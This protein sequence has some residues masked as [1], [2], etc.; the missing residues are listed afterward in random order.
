VLPIFPLSVWLAGSI[1][2]GPGARRARRAFLLI[3]DG[4]DPRAWTGTNRLGRRLAR[5]SPS[6][7]LDELCGCDQVF[8][9]NVRDISAWKSRLIFGSRGLGLLLPPRRS[10]S[11]A[12]DAGSYSSRTRARGEAC[13]SRGVPLLDRARCGSAGLN[14]YRKAQAGYSFRV[15]RHDAAAPPQSRRIIRGLIRENVQSGKIR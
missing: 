8:V 6:T 12:Y 2:V 15:R 3:R 5:S 7:S 11:V 13:R 10:G 1:F 14:R 9:R 4:P